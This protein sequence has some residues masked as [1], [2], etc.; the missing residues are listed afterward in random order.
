MCLG[1]VAQAFAADLDSNQGLTHAVDH[2]HGGESSQLRGT[3][4]RQQASFASSRRRHPSQPQAFQ[5]IAV[6]RMIPL[7][8]W[9]PRV[10]LTQSRSTH[11]Q[12][13]SSSS[14]VDAPKVARYGVIL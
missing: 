5:E 14:I 2:S 6:V 9:Y 1:D 10:Y 13:S 12:H 7:L 3:G 8:K 4:L 11:K